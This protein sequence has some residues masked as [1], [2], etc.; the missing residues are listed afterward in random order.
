LNPFDY[1]AYISALNRRALRY[2]LNSEPLFSLELK[3]S[4]RPEIIKELIEVLLEQNR[5]KE[6]EQLVKKFGVVKHSHLFPGS[7]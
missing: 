6:A 5:K 7:T 1:P 4:G 3:V 2:C